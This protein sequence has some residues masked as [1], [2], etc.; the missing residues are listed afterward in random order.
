MNINH[1]T[2]PQHN[3]KKKTMTMSSRGGGREARSNCSCLELLRLCASC[4][5]ATQRC[6]G[7]AHCTALPVPQPGAAR[8]VCI[9]GRGKVCVTH[10]HQKFLVSIFQRSVASAAAAAVVRLF[11]PAYGL[12]PAEVII[13]INIGANTSAA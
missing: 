12:L 7:A 6:R 3:N 10:A 11:M 4:P 9:I 8:G 5:L 2:P 1:T 13:I